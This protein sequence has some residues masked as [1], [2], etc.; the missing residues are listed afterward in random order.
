MIRIHSGNVQW[1]GVGLALATLCAAGISA[2]SA[3]GPYISVDAVKDDVGMVLSKHIEYVS[4]D[5]ALAPR[6]REA[7]IGV[8][9]FFWV[10]YLKDGQGG[11]VHKRD[12]RRHLFPIL[13]E[14]D[15]YVLGDAGL[16]AIARGMYLERSQA[17]RAMTQPGP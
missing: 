17:L 15:E 3:P 4:V 16:H 8:D 5:P 14:H 13:D 2:M 11:L 9:E 6:E 12:W 1:W 10:S 7:R